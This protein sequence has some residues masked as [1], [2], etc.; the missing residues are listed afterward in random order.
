MLLGSCKVG[1]IVGMLPR[2]Q[3]VFEDK[4]MSGRL[5]KYIATVQCRVGKATPP[6]IAVS[7]RIY[8]GGGARTYCF[9][10]VT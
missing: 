10:I 6:F 5:Y 2:V 7:S 4:I 1:W 3:R 9:L 8:K